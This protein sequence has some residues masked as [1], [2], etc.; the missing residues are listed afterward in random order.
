MWF[1]FS[2]TADGQKLTLTRGIRWGTAMPNR[3]PP[4]PGPNAALSTAKK[5]PRIDASILPAGWTAVSQSLALQGRG[6][7]GEAVAKDSEI[8]LQIDVVE[9][10]LAQ[11]KRSLAAAGIPETPIKSFDVEEEYLIGLCLV[12][13]D[14]GNSAGSLASRETL[15]SGITPKLVRQGR[16]K[17]GNRPIVGFEEVVI[18]ER[19]K[20][21]ILTWRKDPANTAV[22]FLPPFHLWIEV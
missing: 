3:H 10:G 4:P 20:P 5:E 13:Q 14:G 7:E 12:R 2:L 19:P 11:W 22:V 16:E 9:D 1:L 17:F 21:A 15:Y 8:R 6:P 18:A